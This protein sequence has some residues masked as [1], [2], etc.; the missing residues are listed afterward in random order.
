M[1]WIE[2]RDFEEQNIKRGV[3]KSFRNSA[4]SIIVETWQSALKND[5][6]VLAR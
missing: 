1:K 5:G 4:N 3:V 2:W 6:W